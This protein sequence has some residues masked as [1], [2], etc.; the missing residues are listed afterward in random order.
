MADTKPLDI[1][2]G[3]FEANRNKPETVSEVNTYLF[4]ILHSRKKEDSNEIF[5]KYFEL[6]AKI[7]GNDESQIFL[8][9]HQHLDPALVAP[10]VDAKIPGCSCM[11]KILNCLDTVFW[12]TWLQDKIIPYY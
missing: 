12:L 10:I 3:E 8:S 9:L 2:L 1:I 5:K 4:H 11:E 7:H 6:E